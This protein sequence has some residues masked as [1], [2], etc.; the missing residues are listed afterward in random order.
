MDRM[1]AGM[2]VDRDTIPVNAWHLQLHHGIFGVWFFLSYMAYSRCYLRRLKLVLSYI[3]F[4][5]WARGPH[6]YA[7]MNITD[8][9]MDN[10]YESIRAPEISW[11]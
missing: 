4:P 11:I 2:G 9:I 5:F 1:P 10:I 6:G 7:D 3:G 8:M